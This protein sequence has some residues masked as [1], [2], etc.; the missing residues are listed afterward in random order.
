V[1]PATAVLVIR[2][3]F[4]VVWLAPDVFRSRRVLARGWHAP[5]TLPAADHR[6]RPQY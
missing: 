6:I 3:G 5:G 4:L 2:V 1:L